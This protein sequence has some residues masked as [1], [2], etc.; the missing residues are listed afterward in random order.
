[1]HSVR[2]KVALHVG[3]IKTLTRHDNMA[4]L[5]G[6]PPEHRAASGGAAPPH[7][8]PSRREPQRRRAC[9]HTAQEAAGCRAAARTDVLN[10]LHH[11]RK[12][13]EADL[14][15]SEARREGRGGASVHM[16]S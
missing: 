10:R 16:H 3:S 8:G 11:L 4:R 6:A 1:V 13:H 15:R 5:L 7:T 9:R 14:G 2:E 12:P